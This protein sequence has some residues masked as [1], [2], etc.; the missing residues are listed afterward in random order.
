MKLMARKFLRNQSEIEYLENKDIYNIIIRMVYISWCFLHKL[1]TW[2]CL[3]VVYFQKINSTIK[4][5]LYEKH[6][7]EKVN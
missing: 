7:S 6:F 4:E 5:N 1:L 2:A 3:C